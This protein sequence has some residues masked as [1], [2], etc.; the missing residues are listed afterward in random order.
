MFAGMG[1]LLRAAATTWEF[2]TLLIDAGN[3][4]AAGAAPVASGE[5]GGDFAALLAATGTNA[6]GSTIRG[7]VLDASRKFADDTGGTAREQRT[8][9]DKTGRRFVS[10]IAFRDNG[11]LYGSREAQ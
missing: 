2:G 4:S 5:A 6:L 8:T 11:F 7:T 10:H 1:K 3:A 9:S